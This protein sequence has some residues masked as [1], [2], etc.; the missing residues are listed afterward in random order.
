M[1]LDIKVV[2]LGA[3]NVGKTCLINRYCNGV[4]TDKTKSTIGAGFYTHTTNVN[5]T[6]VSMMLWDTAGEERFRAVTPSLLRGTGGVV[7]AFDLFEPRSL[8]ELDVYYDMYAT[9]VG[10]D[11]TEDSP[12]LLLGN[13]SDLGAPVLTDDT[14]KLWMERHNVYHYYKVSAKTGDN[15]DVAFQEFT[16]RLVTIMTTA[17]RMPI[18]ISVLPPAPRPVEQTQKKKCC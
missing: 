13:K 14:V 3:K 9:N 16:E 15:V 1:T 6:S 2:V 18:A 4:F 12:I 10:I 5:G 7:L 17:T 8:E 11:T